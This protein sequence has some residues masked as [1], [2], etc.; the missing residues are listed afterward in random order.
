M[1]S[2]AMSRL[3]GTES[4]KSQP[5]SLSSLSSDQK[6]DRFNHV[7]RVSDLA[8]PYLKTKVLQHVD[9]MITWEAII[10]KLETSD[11]Y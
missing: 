4:Y 1:I 5:N 7:L 9:L 11:C 2:F 6:A 3:Y 8:A 10:L